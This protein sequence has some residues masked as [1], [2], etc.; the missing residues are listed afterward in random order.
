MPPNFPLP[1]TKTCQHTS[2]LFLSRMATVSGDDSSSNLSNAKFWR[3]SGLQSKNSIY[4][5]ILKNI[6]LFERSSIDR[7]IQIFEKSS[8]VRNI[9]LL[10][11]SSFVRNIR[12]IEKSSFV[13]KSEKEWWIT[14]WTEFECR[15]CISWR[16]FWFI[17]IGPKWLWYR[18]VTLEIP[19]FIILANVNHTGCIMP[20]LWFIGVTQFRPPIGWRLRQSFKVHHYTRTTLDL[21]TNKMKGFEKI[22]WWIH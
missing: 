22:L 13:R 8:I 16:T 21:L 7:N 20:R 4:S 3:H 18:P 12:L 1:S 14:F 2:V 11:K 17:W 15:R 19:S 10:E 5:T 6:R 9:R